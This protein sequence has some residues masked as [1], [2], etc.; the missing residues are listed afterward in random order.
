MAADADNEVLVLARSFV[1][2]VRHEAH[3]VA[4]GS[5]LEDVIPGRDGEGWDLDVGVVLVDG[6]LLPVAVVGAVIEPIQKVGGK[7]AGQRRA[8]RDGRDVED[9][10]VLEGENGAADEGVGALTEVR[11]AVSLGEERGPRF[12]EPLVEGAALVGPVLVIVA[13][14]DNGAYSGQMGRMAYCRQHLRAPT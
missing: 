7:V 3:V 14:G 6:P 10:I 5:A 8:I 9:G 13:G 2:G 11:L 1:A 4:E 12:V